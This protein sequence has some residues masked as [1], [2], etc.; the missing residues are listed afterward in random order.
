MLATFSLILGCAVFWLPGSALAAPA[1]HEITWAHNAAA[2]V[3]NFVVF[4]SAVQGDQA[5]SRQIYV[6]KPAS[7]SNSGSLQTFSAIV[8]VELDEYV[9]VAALAL[10]GS[11][12]ELSRWSG[13]PPSQPGQ[14]FLIP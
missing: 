12:S 2:E 7:Q 8:S 4:V 9:A 14:P 1:L 11:L 5:N 3:Q 10:D 13:L 6:G